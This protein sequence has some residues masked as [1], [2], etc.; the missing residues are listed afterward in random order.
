LREFE[1]TQISRQ[2]R[3]TKR[4]TF[5]TFV[6]ISSKNSALEQRAAQGSKG[7]HKAAQ[8][9][10]ESKHRKAQDSTGQHKRVQDS[11]RE[12]RT[13]QA[14]ATAHGKDT[15]PKIQNKYSQK[16]NCAATVP[17]PTFIFM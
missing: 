15:T 5:K 11:T 2:S 9:S 13:A 7:W 6:W 4:K 8:E 16:R 14:S 12:Y 3:I 17:I 10:T 1:E